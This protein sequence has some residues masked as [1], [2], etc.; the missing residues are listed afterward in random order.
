MSAG[1]STG[2]VQLEIRDTKL[3][4]AVNTIAADYAKARSAELVGMQYDD[5]GNLVENPNAEWAISDTTRVKIRSIVT[6]AFQD[7]TDIKLVR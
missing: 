6:E 5:D 1:A 2:L 4:S 7:E 3:I